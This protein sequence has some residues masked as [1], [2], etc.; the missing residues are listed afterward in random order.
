MIFGSLSVVILFSIITLILVLLK[1]DAKFSESDRILLEDFKNNTYLALSKMKVSCKQDEFLTS[2]TLRQKKNEGIYYYE[3]TCNKPNF[4]Y[5]LNLNLNLIPNLSKNQTLNYNEIFGSNSTDSTSHNDPSD[6]INTPA[7]NISLLNNNTLNSATNNSNS[8]N[9]T[10]ESLNDWEKQKLPDLIYILSNETFDFSNVSLEDHEKEVSLSELIE[11]EI[12]SNKTS[13]SSR[14]SSN[15][16]PPPPPNIQKMNQNKTLNN[17][18]PAFINYTLPFTPK[19]IFCDSNSNINAKSLN[20]E[21]NTNSTT[22]CITKDI[23][24]NATN[25]YY[26]S[27]LSENATNSTTFLQNNSTNNPLFLQAVWYQTQSVLV[28]SHNLTDVFNLQLLEIICEKNFVLAEFFLLFEESSS[29]FSYKYRCVGSR[30]KDLGLMCKRKLSN[31]KDSL[32][33]LDSLINIKVEAGKEFKFISSFKFIQWNAKILTNY[34]EYSV[35]KID[36]PDALI[37]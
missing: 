16:P 29:S 35:C 24:N 6:I 18:D 31:F 10:N 13:N 33:S 9:S 11:D 27:A 3:F 15:K 25:K 21:K 19:I 34:Y 2:F 8:S 36:I 4:A 22:G 12:F 1:K 7:I 37:K 20:A 26:F 23:E 30:I 32:S 17:L 5:L 28:P 14:S